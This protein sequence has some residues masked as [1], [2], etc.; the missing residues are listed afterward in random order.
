MT[1]NIRMAY[2]VSR[3][4]SI[5]HTFILNEVRGLRAKGFDIHVA[6]VNAADR[7][8]AQLTAVEGLEMRTTRYIKNTPKLRIL[9]V[10]LKSLLISPLGFLR[11]FRYA[12]TLAGAD[13]RGMLWSAFYFV[14]ALLI[15][16]WMRSKKLDHLHVHFATPASTVALIVKKIMGCTLSIT[17]HGPD[18]FYDATQYHLARKVAESDFLVAISDFARSQLMKLS[19]YEHWHKIGVARLG[20]DTER[21][22]PTAGSVHAAKQILCVGRLTPAKGQ[23]IL[24]LALAELRRMHPEALLRFVGDGPDRASLE[25][26]ASDLDLT[27]NVRF[28]G[29]INQ[30]RIHAFYQQATVFALPSFAEGI[31]VVLMESMAMGV[32]VISTRITGIPE[33]ITDGVNGILCAA[34]NHK[35]LA[36]AIARVFEND[37]LR[38]ELAAAGRAQVIENYNSSTNLSKLAALFEERLLELKKVPAG[39]AADLRLREVAG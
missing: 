5:S 4:P 35:E 20:V 16:D 28:E 27:S 11:A 8:E 9:R 22:A 18:E 32:P 34:S 10:L 15:A 33:L 1:S 36:S 30:D 25:K 7:P 19:E 17:V 37:P 23:H 3:Y 26:L 38:S 29:N 31:P 39:T 6:S 2:L 14:E 24:L 21:F 13:I 12:L